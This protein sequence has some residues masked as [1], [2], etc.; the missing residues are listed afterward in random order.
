MSMP[1]PSHGA[2]PGHRRNNFD[3]LRL[4]AALS[5]VFS[6]S[7]LIAEGSEASEPFVWLTGNQCI[8]GLIGVFVFFVISGY[9]VTESWCRSPL[10]GRFLLRRTLRIYPGLVVNVALCALVLG[11]VITSLPLADY[12]HGPELSDF[13]TKTLSLNPGPL[14]LPGVLFA[15]NSVGLHINGSLWTLRYEAMMYLMIVVLGM[16]RMLRLP[17][18]L[19]LTALGIAAVYFEKALTPLGDIGEWAWFLG[20]FGA[21]MVLHFLRDRLV[22]DWRGALV[23]LLVLVI[24]ARLGQLIMLFPLAGAYLTIWFARRYDRWLDY[25]RYCGDLS[26]GLYIY[27]WP[28]EQLVMWL[29]GGRAAWWQVFLGSLAIALPLAWLSWHG[30]EKWALRWGRTIGRRP[31][32]AVAPA[33]ADG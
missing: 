5:V 28:A 23:A 10:P 32:L 30:V 29:S 31:S 1:K 12:F 26:Y 14:Q 4:I 9:L 6:H 3:P 21:G 24:F 22:F 19:A 16:L 18:C 27:G 8:L 20:F 13:L 2:D 33:P 17:T 25:S 15:K 7:F 11:P